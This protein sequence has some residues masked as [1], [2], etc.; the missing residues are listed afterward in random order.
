MLSVNLLL[1][2]PEAAASLS[3]T[4]HIPV[5]WKIHKVP[6]YEYC[7]KSTCRLST[8]SLILNDITGQIKMIGSQ[9]DQVQMWGSGESLGIPSKQTL[10][11]ATTPQP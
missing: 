7:R 2:R 10:V 6:K 5:F 1:R 4:S 9:D 11:L 8:I 3:P